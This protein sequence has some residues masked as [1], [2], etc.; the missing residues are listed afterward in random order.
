MAAQIVGNIISNNTSIGSTSGGGL[1]LFG[2]GAVLV[3][4]NVIAHNVTSGNA[5]CGWGGGINSVNFTQATFID[6]LIVGNSACFGGG[7][8]WEGTTGLNLWVNNTIAD[9][10]A[11][12]YAG[13][14]IAGFT[15]NDLYNNII[16]AASGPA[17]FCEFTQV[18][19]FYANDV[20]SSS[21]ASWGGS[22]TDQTGLNG[23]ISEDPAFIDPAHLDYRLK[24]TSPAI[25]TGNDNAPQLPAVDL[26]GSARVFDGN[27]DGVPHVDIGAV[28]YHNH[29]PTVS[30]GPDQTITLDSG[31]TAGVT[32]T[33][34]GSDPEGDALTYTWTSSFGTMTGATI[35]LTP[36]A[37]TYTLMVTVDDGNGGFASDTVVVAVLDVT[38]PTITSATASPS[39][40]AVAGHRMVPVVVSV[41]ASDQCGGS[42]SCRIVNVTS[43]EPQDGLGDGDTSPDWEITGDLTL[44]VRAERAGGGTGRVYTITIVCVDAAGNQTTST[45]KVTV[46]KD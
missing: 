21:A 2:A 1:G 8:D 45:V 41:S 32:L 12:N 40:I 29:A 23:N 15:F 37:G 19:H 43:N 28:E 39:V 35:S 46:L 30:A 4:R 10:E 27:G 42:V 25:D 24:M 18:Q 33:A 7:V 26:S 16:T 9:N 36:P 14:Y 11:I 5:G 17:V 22:C 34:T 3:E 20:F 13:L 6:N 31:C 38:P 44:N